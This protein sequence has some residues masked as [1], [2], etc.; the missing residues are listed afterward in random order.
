MAV[1]ERE[2]DPVTGQYTTGHDWNGIKELDNRVPRPIL[3]FLIATA[4]FSIVYWVLMPAWP[5]GVTYTK[6]LLGIDQRQTVEKAVEE[7]AAARRAAW[8]EDIA[9]LD[10]AEIRERPELMQIVR[11]SGSTL[12]GDNCAVCHGLDGSGNPGFPS[13][14]DHAWLWG[15]DPEIVAETLRI[16]INSTHPETRF[17]QMPAFGRDGILDRPSISSIVSFIRNNAEGIEDL[18]PLDTKGV[19]EGARLFA[20]NCAACHGEDGRGD[21]AMG[22]PNLMDDSW[23]TGSDRESLIRTIS[24]GRQGHM[25]HWEDRLSELDR[26]ILTL[27]VTEI[28]NGKPEA[29]R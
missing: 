15:G 9:K 22:V 27:Y 16:G 4:L 10:F 29:E 28:I 19:E 21:P 12:F 3:F 20:E 14:A 11:E 17:A 13:L 25:P 8:A 23:L 6:G 5:I 24:E 1:G 18:G 26:K 7:A 2:R